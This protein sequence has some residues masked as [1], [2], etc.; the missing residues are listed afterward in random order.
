MNVSVIIP[1]LNEEQTIGGVIEEFYSSLPEAKIYVLD[2]NSTD[3]TR[4]VSI[5]HGVSVINIVKPGKGAAVREGIREILSIDNH[6]TDAFIMVDGDMTYKASD[7]IELIEYA[8]RESVDV[9]VGDRISSG[10]YKNENNRLFHNNGNHLVCKLVNKLYGSSYKDVMSGYRLLTREF[11]ENFTPRYDGFE[12][13]TE[14]SIYCVVNGF[15]VKEIPVSYRDRPHGSS[16]KLNT[17]KDG[18]KVLRLVIRH[19]L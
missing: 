14:M 8:E 9:V 10:Y 2:N 7:A 3:N 4:G 19:R 18:M 6:W 15:S 16:S 5:A 17:V 13:E 11:A 12:L 1:C